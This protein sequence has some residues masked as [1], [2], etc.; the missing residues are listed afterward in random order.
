MKAQLLFLLIV[1]IGI[2]QPLD[3]VA[4]TYK[5]KEGKCKVKF[6]ATPKEETKSKT[7]ATTVKIS[8]KKDDQ[9][10]FV[11][12]TLH[13]IK[14]IDHKDMAKVSL[15]AFIENTGGA[16]ISQSEWIVKGNSGL[17]ATI[18][19]EDKNALIEYRVVLIG[20]LQYQ[21]A[22]TATKDDYDSDMAAK[23]IKSFKV[24]K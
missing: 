9:V 6:P 8:C 18:N 23:F 22:V 24:T 7:N 21:I 5:S 13:E 1:L 14:I 11:G 20:Q 16:A 4:Q 19:L 2:A 17:K 10:Y 15:E 12:Y 3:V